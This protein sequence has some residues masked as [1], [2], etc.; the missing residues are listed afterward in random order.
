MPA[1]AAASDGAV[2]GC[3]RIAASV[4]F[5][6]LFS[7]SGMDRVASGSSPDPR[8]LVGWDESVGLWKRSGAGHT[9]TLQ[10][11]ATV[12]EGPT[13]AARLVAAGLDGQLDALPTGRV[14][15][16]LES[17]QEV[18]GPRTGCFRWYHE[19]REIRDTNAAFFIGLPLVVLRAEFADRLAPADRVVLDRML[20]RLR[21][22]C[23]R[24]AA[25]PLP[26]YPNKHLG[27]LVCAWLLAEQLGG[28]TPELPDRLRAAAR[29]WRDAEWGW[30]EHMSDIYARTCLDELAMLLLVSQRLPPDIRM[31]YEQLR[32]E[33]LRINDL[34]AGGPRV[35]AIR[36][37]AFSRGTKGGSYRDAV[38][39]WKTDDL[40]TTDLFQP[41]RG[42]ADRLGWH[43]AAPAAAP[44]A[45]RLEVACHGGSRAMAVI[46]GPLRLGAMSRYPIMDGIDQRTWGLS[47][48]SFPVAAWHAAGDWCYLQWEAVEDGR[49]RAHPAETR[50][51][52]YH[53]NALSLQLDPP[54][55]GQTF[56]VR[57]GSAFVVLRRMPRTSGGWQELIDRVRLTGRHG[58]VEELEDAAGRRLRLTY[59]AE[60]GPPR[61]LT[62]RFLGLDQQ[63]IP[64]LTR[65]GDR[66]I[67]WTV[68]HPRAADSRPPLGLWVW[69]LGDDLVAA[70]RIERIDAGWRLS[71]PQDGGRFALRI[72]PDAAAPLHVE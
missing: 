20:T 13:A 69:S 44:A 54:P 48:Q 63:L 32:D 65:D 62:I 59:P 8:Y 57:H 15:A 55:V 37:Y 45:E 1:R 29:Y 31:A 53:D 36:S 35:P 72:D 18:A 64:E 61:R 41:L 51:V 68:R 7:A 34:Y 25:S 58:Q 46:D 10:G 43:A 23:D 42:L 27:D 38:R 17:M 14:L 47:W 52:S 50:A 3:S 19:E 5:A 60:N 24:E 49:R 30:G 9:K 33:L 56:A 26:R 6:V 66:T 28:E 67:D 11:S 40:L 12:H 22:W 70:P 39:P 71:W 2:R 21:T 16:A 4:A